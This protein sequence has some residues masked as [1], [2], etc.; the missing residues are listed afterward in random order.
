[1]GENG[2]GDGRW[3]EKRLG[4]GRRRGEER[5]GGKRG[6]SGKRGGRWGEPEEWACWLLHHPVN[7]GRYDGNKLHNEAWRQLWKCVQEATLHPSDGFF[8]FFFPPRTSQQSG[9]FGNLAGVAPKIKHATNLWDPGVFFSFWC[10]VTALY[11]PRGH[12]SIKWSGRQRWRVCLASLLQRG[13]R[14]KWQNA[15][16]WLPSRE[17][18]AFWYWYF[19]MLQNYSFK[20]LKSIQHAEINIFFFLIPHTIFFLLNPRVSCRLL[21]TRQA[22][23]HLIRWHD[24]TWSWHRSTPLLL[25]LAPDMVEM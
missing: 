18:S 10:D 20:S 6:D 22:C 16:L 24:M 13:R 19:L 1:M 8:F 7:W 2:R 3:D 4:D 23:L 17:T 12:L 15:C 5:E 25:Q 9:R 21:L 11:F 14:I